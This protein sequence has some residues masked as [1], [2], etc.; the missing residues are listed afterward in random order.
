MKKVFFVILAG[1][2]MFTACKKEIINTPS[3]SF[4][5]YDDK[6]VE[7][8]IKDFNQKLQQKS[9]ESMTIEDAVWCI[10]AALNYN[11]CRLNNL[12][13]ELIEDSILVEYP[14]INNRLNFDDVKNFYICA[15]KTLNTHLKNENYNV[16]VID[17]VPHISNDLLNAKIYFTFCLVN[18]SKFITYP[19]SFSSSDYWRW[20]W[21][22]G[23][24]DGSITTSDARYQLEYWLNSGLYYNSKQFFTDIVE[25]TA[26]VDPFSNRFK[27]TNDTVPNDNFLD[28]KIFI[29]SRQGIDANGNLVNQTSFINNTYPGPC[30]SPQE[31]NFY[32]WSYRSVALN[33]SINDG[34][35][36]Q[37]KDVILYKIS[38]F[39]Q[40]YYPNILYWNTHRLRVKYGILHT[41]NN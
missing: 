7:A 32:K 5:P 24:C 13:G 6:A 30:I 3:A 39:S 21:G 23:K 37:G 35:R 17:I 10:E 16:I 34:I 1:G 41:S 29:N 8:R 4:N 28:Y 15:E 18:N 33:D 25:K 11:F 40:S 36:P 20:S 19:N 27:N 26:D 14:L 12:N 22:I 9:G 2:I 38:G 31:L